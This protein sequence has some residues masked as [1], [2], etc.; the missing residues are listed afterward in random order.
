MYY[1]FNSG[2]DKFD[3]WFFITAT[4]S[5]LFLFYYCICFIYLVDSSYNVHYRNFG[6]RHEEYIT[7]YS[8]NVF[9]CH[10]NILVFGRCKC[11]DAY[12]FFIQPSCLP[13]DELQNCFSIT[14]STV[15]RG[16]V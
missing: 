15:I 16:A 13:C 3:K 9:L 4:L 8:Q 7:K 14:G 5:W 6:K 12:H 11:I 1:H 10:T 2:S